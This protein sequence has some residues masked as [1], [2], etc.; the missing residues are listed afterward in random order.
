MSHAY[1]FL[2]EMWRFFKFEFRLFFE[3]TPSRIRLGYRKDLESF[4]CKIC[5]LGVHLII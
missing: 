2:N 3:V 1:N 5:S 4:C